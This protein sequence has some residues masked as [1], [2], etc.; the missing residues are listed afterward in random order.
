MG[1]AA[2]SRRHMDSTP[3]C[4]RPTA[5]PLAIARWL[6]AVAA[7]VFVLVVV[8]GITR[9]TESGLSITEWQLVAGAIPP[10]SHADWQRAFDLYQAT[11]E[12]R[13]INGPA[14]MDLA[15]FQL[16]YF[17]EWLHR[18]LGR[19]VG[20]A[21][22]LPLIWFAVRRQIPRGYGWR[23]TLL[24]LLGASQGALGWYM[25]QSGLV[26]RTDV[27]HFRLSAHLVT[28]LLILA[29]LVWTALDLRQI[30]RSGENRPARL[31]PVAIVA[32]LLLVVQLLLGAW[33]AGLDAGQ[34]ASDWPLMQGR[35]VPDGIDTTRG[36]LFALTHDP[37][38][39]HFLHRWWAWVAVAG[40]IILARR[41]KPLDR[42]ASIAIHSA[43]GT[44]LLLGIA[45]VMSGMNITLAVLHQ[46]VGALVVVATAWGAHVVGK[47]PSPLAG[48]GF[49]PT[50]CAPH[51]TD[52]TSSAP[53][54]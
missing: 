2:I 23:L 31:V 52:A 5:R 20:V 50:T 24:L 16:I 18:L 45:T 21:F 42:R 49:R 38:L 26:N 22:A 3:S 32:G 27:S 30:V 53:T 7:L 11:P 48:E 43:F 36:A 46:A 6:L 15:A 25:V 1:K 29:G 35:L 9:L 33:V 51:A 39:I 19:L 40:L 54:A 8:G 4:L 14:G 28:A 13:E 17:W 41:V 47:S 34:V 12:Y 37:Y 10:L 44:Q